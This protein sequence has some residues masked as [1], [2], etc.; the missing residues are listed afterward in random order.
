MLDSPALLG[1]P[2]RVAELP[3]S[4]LEMRVAM[5]RCS[6]ARAVLRTVSGCFQ[7]KQC[8]ARAV[9]QGVQTSGFENGFSFSSRPVT[10]VKR[11]TCIGLPMQLRRYR[12]RGPLLCNNDVGKDVDNGVGRVIANRK[13]MLIVAAHAG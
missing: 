4:M 3:T 2:L 6:Y 9:F 1:T 11:P 10:I 5:S 13:T 7:I 12:Q 8:P